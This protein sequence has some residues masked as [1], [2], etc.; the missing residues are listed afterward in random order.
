MRRVI[1]LL[2]LG[3]L[4]SLT[5]QA[6][7]QSRQR[8]AAQR[9]QDL[10]DVAMKM[11]DA[12]D[13]KPACPLLE[14]SDKLDPGMG[15]RFRLA[16][17][18]EKTGRLAGAWQLFTAVAEAARIER[19]S[20]REQV[21]RDRAAALAPKLPRLVLN[22]PPEVSTLIGLEVR[23]RGEKIFPDRWGVPLPADLGEQALEVRASGKKTWRQTVK[24][25]KPQQSQT[26]T[27]PMPE[28]GQDEP[29]SAA[30]TPQEQKLEP[31]PEQEPEATGPFLGIH[32]TPQRIGAVAAGGVGVLG[33]TL[34][35]I[36]GASAASQWGD[37]QDTCEGGDFTRCS[38]AGVTKAED[39]S[40]AATVSTVSF[41][42]GLAGLG[43]GAYLWFTAPRDE[44]APSRGWV[45]VPAVGPGVAAGV[46]RAKF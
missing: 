20:D 10:F 3:A 46:L 35:T 18:Y 5:A 34:G 14:Q 40:T 26:V 11:M 39:A 16:E 21:A 12:G 25:E 31:Q 29:E 38:P 7:A 23:F 36:F 27:I 9:A 32:W 43:A 8:P 28:D 15:T 42:I 41:V 4:T 22:V 24:F 33:L 45:I 17:C 44:P 1:S 30:E 13:Y 2:V 37:A 6:A 19:V